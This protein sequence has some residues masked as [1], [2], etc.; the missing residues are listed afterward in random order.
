MSKRLVIRDF[1]PVRK[2]SLLGFAK[3]ELPIGLV[4][5]DVTVHES[6][7]K[8]WASM[9]SKPVLDS[10]GRHKQSADGKREY[11]FIISW[12]SRE[13]SDGFSEAVLSALDADKPGWDQN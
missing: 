5:S 8:R 10:D 13:L 4:I 2:N 9:P 1:R 3:I 7:G 12:R 6:H 11:A